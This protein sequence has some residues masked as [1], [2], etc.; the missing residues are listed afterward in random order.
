MTSQCPL[1]LHLTMG[2]RTGLGCNDCS[3]RFA[4][5]ERPMGRYALLI[6]GK[7]SMRGRNVYFHLPREE[8]LRHVSKV[9]LGKQTW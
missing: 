9:H 4:H 6:Q 2:N 7:S 3:R 8:L 5:A 1:A